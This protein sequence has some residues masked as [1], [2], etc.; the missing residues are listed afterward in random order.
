MGLC[1]PPRDWGR[2]RRGESNGKHF[3]IRKLEQVTLSWTRNEAG[4]N[5][6]LIGQWTVSSIAVIRGT[7]R[8]VLPQLV[9]QNKRIDNRLLILKEC[10]ENILTKTRSGFHMNC[11]I[12]IGPRTSSP[13]VFQKEHKQSELPLVATQSNRLQS[14]NKQQKLDP[15]GPCQQEFLFSWRQITFY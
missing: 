1:L 8:P 14:G 6:A 7:H 12:R 3:Q 15:M 10:H 2:T 4:K 11:G 5:N 9:K 13:R